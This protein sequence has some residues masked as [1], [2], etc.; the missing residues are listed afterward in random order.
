MQARR[1]KRYKKKRLNLEGINLRLSAGSTKQPESKTD[2][3]EQRIGETRGSRVVSK[4][5]SKSLFDSESRRNQNISPTTQRGK[6]TKK[7]AQ[8]I[9]YE[10]P[11]TKPKHLKRK[12]YQPKTMEGIRQQVRIL[13]SNF[14]EFQRQREDARTKYQW[15]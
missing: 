10:I 13:F 3:N 4:T 2:K 12:D 7:Q 14:R 8:L 1:Q 11:G 9:I 5:S 15:R 6:L